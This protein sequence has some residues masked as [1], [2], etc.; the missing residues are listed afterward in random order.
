MRKSNINE[1]PVNNGNSILETQPQLN[2]IEMEVNPNEVS[3]KENELPTTSPKKSKQALVKSY[4][5]NFVFYQQTLG[6]S[7]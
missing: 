6:V 5:A 7:K 4:I 3:S 1:V 2:Q